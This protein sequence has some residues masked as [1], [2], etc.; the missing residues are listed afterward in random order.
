MRHTS[1]IWVGRVALAAGLALGA[2]HHARAA[3]AA[4]S[5]EHF[6]FLPPV[7]TVSA[8]TTVTWTNHDEEEHTVTSSAGAFSSAGLD[9]EE[10]F[11]QTFTQPGTYHYHCA[12]HPHMRATVIVRG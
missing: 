6:A 8:G 3:T 11:S 7:L 1:R 2:P 10:T 12:L 4:V 9:S 5:I